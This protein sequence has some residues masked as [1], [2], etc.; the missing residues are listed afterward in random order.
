MNIKRV[1]PIVR[2]IDESRENYV[3]NSHLRKK[4]FSYQLEEQMQDNISSMNH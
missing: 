3:K 1:G 4:L 2:Q